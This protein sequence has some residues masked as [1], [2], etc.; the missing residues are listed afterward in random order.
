MNGS[1]VSETQMNG[2]WLEQR[3]GVKILHLSGSHYEMG[4]QHGYLLQDEIEMNY[5]TVFSL[6]DEGIYDAI[7]G[8]WNDSVRN[9]IPQDYLYELEGLANGSGQDFE[10]VVVFTLGLATFLFGLDCMEMSAWGPATADGR[11]LHMRSYDIPLY[12]KD[13]DSGIYLQENQILIVRKPQNEHL[14][15]YTSFA[16]DIFSRGGLNSEGIAVSTENSPSDAINYNATWFS[17]RILQV[18][19]TASDL[20]DALDIMTSSKQ[21]ASTYIISDGHNATACVYEETSNFS[22][23]G[24]WDDI[25]ESRPPFWQIDHVIRRKNFYIDPTAASSQRNH[26]DPR[27]YF[28]LGILP[29][30]TNW[31]TPWRFFK[32]LSIEIEKRWGSLDL[33]STMEMLRSIYRGETDSI[34][35]L[36]GKLGLEPFYACR[37]WVACPE[38]GDM[39]ISFA[40]D[41]YQAQYNSIHRFNLFD[42]YNS[43]PP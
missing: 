21:G 15:M 12:A 39:L 38:T 33:N 28:I 11:L 14:S 8:L 20:Q 40:D 3:D 13:P 6:D 31:Y 41:R 30:N 1:V 35:H 37:Q 18:L 36:Y 27:L 7:L 26:Y 29:G 34:L 5:R 25:V 32:T 43:E 42:L 10:D 9:H 2:G 22:Y 4:F 23:V 19:D 17:C 16:G 24:T